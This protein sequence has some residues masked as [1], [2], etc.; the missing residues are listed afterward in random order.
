M[1]SFLIKVFNQKCNFVWFSVFIFQRY[2]LFTVELFVVKYLSLIL[3]QQFIVLQKSL[4]TLINWL[5]IFSYDKSEREIFIVKIGNF[6]NIE[7]CRASFLLF[8]LIIWIDNSAII[9]S[10]FDALWSC[11]KTY[12][13]HPINVC[14]LHYFHIQSN[15]F[16]FNLC[17]LCWK[18]DF[19]YGNLELFLFHSNIVITYLRRR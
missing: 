1:L 8:G 2:N 19:R 4:C 15:F 6:W 12:L 5:F 14:K 18:F 7:N 17:K 10:D 16:V 9:T 11:I 3:G 13:F